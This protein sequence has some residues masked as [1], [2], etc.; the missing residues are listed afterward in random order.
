M[1]LYERGK[2]GIK[3]YSDT[4][5]RREGIHS[6]WECTSFKLGRWWK[7]Q[8]RHNQNRNVQIN[9]T[10][11]RQNVALHLSTMIILIIALVDILIDIFSRQNIK[12][13][14]QF[15][16]Y[17]SFILLLLLTVWKC[18]VCQIGVLIPQKQLD[19]ITYSHFY[20]RNLSDLGTIFWFSKLNAV[21]CFSKKGAES[22]NISL[23]MVSNI[24]IYIFF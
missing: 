16:S 7:R 11:V 22:P 9:F 2:C 19:L 6:W 3:L 4:G 1:C 8:T 12:L 20:L 24:L 21:L 13:Y 14:F 15:Y 5:G 18:L 10:K 17:F 23:K